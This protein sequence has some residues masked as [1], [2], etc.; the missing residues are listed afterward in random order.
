MIIVIFC[1]ALGARRV[2]LIAQFRQWGRELPFTLESALHF[3]RVRLFFET[4]HLPEKDPFV[5][6]PNGVNVRAT[7]TV[8]DEY[9]YATLARLFPR[10]FTL[11]QRVRW[12]EGIWFSLGAVVL[13]LWIARL[14]GYPLA[15][16]LAGFAYAVMPAAVVRSTGQELSHENSAL[17]LLILH[18]AFDSESRRASAWHRLFFTVASALALGLALWCWDLIQFYVGLW[19]LV[20]AWF[21]LRAKDPRFDFVSWGVHTA[22]L[23]AIALVNPYHRTHGLW[24]SPIWLLMYGVWLNRWLRAA[25]RRGWIR[26]AWGAAPS[27]AAVT[28]LPLFIGM[29]ANAIFRES[30]G[31]FL[32][33]LWAKLWFLNEKPGNPG[34]LNFD[35]RILW[36][37]GL[38][39]PSLRLTLDLFPWILPF[40]LAL[41]PF[42]VRHSEA[43][44]TPETTQLLWFLGASLTTYTLFARFHVFVAVFAAAAVGYGLAELWRQ[45]RWVRW[46]GIACAIGGLVFEAA[47]SVGR[48]DRWARTGVY[49]DEL[50]ELTSWLAEH[51][52]PDPVLANFGVSGSILTY[53]G[54]P[55]ILHPKFESPTIRRSVKEYGELLFTGTEREL[56]NW[57]SRK[58]A[59]YFVYSMGEFASK[60]VDQQMR[61]MVNALKPPEYAPAWR[62]EFEPDSLQYFRFVWGNRKYR[63]FDILT[64]GEERQCNAYA[65]SALRALERGDLDAAEYA[66]TQSL[67][68][69]SRNIEAQQV[70]KHVL[71]LRAQ[72]FKTEKGLR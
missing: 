55:I 58:G 30:Y 8:G 13:A 65:N 1:T 20:R 5:E 33:L 19:M 45:R 54:C 12:I 38:N 68:I 64:T 2:V 39:S 34:L 28:A 66:A 25:V 52:A 9:G 26:E 51:V 48:A 17:P 42:W 46:I 44:S 56:R 47:G 59:E 61:Y 40:S 60:G 37:P 41:V 27:L 10:S 70:L 3:R 62:F 31:H 69:D 15:G 29:F 16:F 21:V 43:R 57:A 14:T 72:G 22:V 7:Y 35:Q 71:S 4:G 6:W 49:Y 24:A 23:I 53:G 67:M 63:V 11:P 36:V 32:S 18:L 50:E